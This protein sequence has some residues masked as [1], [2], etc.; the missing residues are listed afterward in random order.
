MIIRE[1]ADENIKRDSIFAFLFSFWQSKKKLDIKNEN[2][3]AIIRYPMY[4]T[5]QVMNTS[6][7]SSLEEPTN[8]V[9]TFSKDGPYPDSNKFLLNPVIKPVLIHHGKI[10]I[11]KDSIMTVFFLISLYSF[12]N[13]LNKNTINTANNNTKA[14]IFVKQANPIKMPA[15]TSHL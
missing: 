14:L 1:I 12:L 8:V 6:K 2:P 3:D 15:K 7:N 11:K 9:V 4:I 13:S 5:T 10:I